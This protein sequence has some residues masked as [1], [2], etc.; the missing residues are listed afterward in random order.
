M[1]DMLQVRANDASTTP[2]A[3]SHN[4][5]NDELSWKPLGNP[6]NSVTSAW[7]SIYRDVR[8]MIVPGTPDRCQAMQP[9]IRSNQVD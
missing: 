8:R 6:T 7:R 1:T 3:C 5:A 4:N 9:S 2:E